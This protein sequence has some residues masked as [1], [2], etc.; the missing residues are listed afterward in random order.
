MQ[1]RLQE[2]TEKIYREGVSK[3]SEEGDKIL[4]DARKEAKKII[5]EASKKAASIEEQASKKAEEIIKNGNSEL[6][7]SF[8]HAVNTL[9]QDLEK[10]ISHNIVSGKV[11]KAFDD[12][13]FIAELIITIFRNWKP[14]TGGSG[15]EVML[16][17]DKAEAIGKR[18]R[19]EIASEL[20]KGLVIKPVSTIASGFEIAP[21][22]GGFKISAT[23]GDIE[24]YLKEFIR[25][26]LKEILFEE[27]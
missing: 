11:A 16:P 15:M 8:R 18:I 27:K 23:G 19:A 6:K 2:L 25:P 12:E 7:I 24:A 22:E 13:N 26:K 3:A 9:R 20:G 5:D 17:S 21:S 1:N 10:T 4:A 14:G